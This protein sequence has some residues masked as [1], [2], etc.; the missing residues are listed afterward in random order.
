MYVV[1]VCLLTWGF[2][3]EIHMW[4]NGLDASDEHYDIAL[5]EVTKVKFTYIRQMLTLCMNAQHR[6]PC[7][8]FSPPQKG[9]TYALEQ[10]ALYARD[11]ALSATVKSVSGF[12]KTLVVGDN[13]EGEDSTNTITEEARVAHL[14]EVRRRGEDE[15]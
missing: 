15:G 3:A 7:S 2:I 10:H 5:E 9:E 4:R 12:F 13:D 14:I 8:L 11:G 1:Y 6:L